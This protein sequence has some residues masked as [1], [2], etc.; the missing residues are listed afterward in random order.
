MGK[1]IEQIDANLSNMHITRAEQYFNSLRPNN[2]NFTQTQ[3][4]SI[5]RVGE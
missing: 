4:K 3:V 2:S 1:L 5:Y